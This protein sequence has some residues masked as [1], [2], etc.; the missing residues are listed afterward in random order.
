MNGG[1]QGEGTNS[2]GWVMNELS[3]EC[4]TEL[5]FSILEPSGER[6]YYRARWELHRAGKQSSGAIQHVK[7]KL[8]EL[9]KEFNLQK[10][11]IES[12]VGKEY[13]PVFSNALHGMTYEDFQQTILLPQNGFTS[14]LR[15][16]NPSEQHCLS[17]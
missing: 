6:R 5:V 15:L 10:V 3:G 7:R 8:Y 4:W 14:S 11:L 1:A 2:V 17:V 12:K 9:D 13:T 16:P